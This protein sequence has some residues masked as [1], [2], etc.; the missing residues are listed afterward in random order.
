MARQNTTIVNNFSDLLPDE[1]VD[2][3]EKLSRIYIESKLDSDT[4]RQ[5]IYNLKRQLEQKTRAEEHLNN[6]L[7]AITEHHEAEI[8]KLSKKYHDENDGL[9]QKVGQL[10]HFKENYSVLETELN[11]LKKEKSSVVTPALSALKSIVSDPNGIKQQQIDKLETENEILIDKCNELNDK[12]ME[13]QKQLSA[14][15]VWNFSI[16]YSKFLFKK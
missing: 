3:Y 8:T 16:I 4:I 9:R 13:T 12:C 11:C 5:Q 1:M 7:E 14:L 10:R 6:E 2:E 15:K